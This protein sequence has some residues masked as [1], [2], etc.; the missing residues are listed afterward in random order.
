MTLCAAWTTRQDTDFYPGSVCFDDLTT[1]CADDDDCAGDC[2]G[3]DFSEELAWRLGDCAFQVQID[4]EGLINVIHSV[5]NDYDADENP[6]TLQ[7]ADEWELQIDSGNT[8]RGFFSPYIPVCSDDL[9]TPC[10]KNE[11][12]TPATCVDDH[13][14][15]VAD[16]SCAAETACV[17]SMARRASATS[18]LWRKRRSSHQNPRARTSWTNATT[19]RRSDGE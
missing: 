12:C 16:G 18:H 11:D 10:T 13:Y 2:S 9:T 3:A 1:P 6:G 14:P 5:E 19:R 7:P 15:R 8:Y 17:E 4:S